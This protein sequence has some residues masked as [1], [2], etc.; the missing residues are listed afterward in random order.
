MHNQCL[1]AFFAAYVAGG[2][3][4]TVAVAGP[5]AE[6]LPVAAMNASDTAAAPVSNSAYLPGRDAL[7]AAAWSGQLTIGQARMETSPQLAQPLQDGRDARLFPGVSL[8]FFTDGDLLVPVQRG[9]MVRETQSM[10]TP[11]YWRVI[12]QFGRVWREPGDGN[13][14][15]AAVPLNL[16]NDTENHAHQGVATFLYRD[17]EISGLRMQFVQQTG[18]YL[19][20]Q[21][22][23]MWGTARATLAAGNIG[24]L[25]T[26]RDAAREEL[27]SRLPS[28]PWSELVKQFPP[29]T[30]DG[31]GGPLLPKWQVLNAL[32][33][34]GTL[35]HQES[36][37]PYGPFPYPLEMRFGVRSVMKSVAAPLALLRLAEVYGP[38]VLALKIG[39]YVKGLDPKF[40]R[41]RFIDAVNMATGFGGMG[42]LKTHPNDTSDGYL[43]GDYDAWYTAPSVADKI[44]QINKNLRPYPWEPGMVMRYRDQ[45]FFLLGLAIEGFLKSVRGVD[46]DLWDM[47]TTEVFKPIGVHH[48]PA[49]RTREP[50]NRDGVIWVN[51][52]YYPSIDDLAKIAALYQNLGSHNGKQLLHRQLTQNLL[53][54]RNAIV[55][56][57]DASLGFAASDVNQEQEKHYLMGF[58]YL[59]YVGSRSKKLHSIPA[60][61]GAGDNR[62]TIFPNGVIAVTMA[63][64][65]GLPPGENANNGDAQATLR[66]VDRMAPF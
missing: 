44:A 9:T 28:K 21:H 7:P 23:V 57:G 19:L 3:F 50:G 31:F 16:V 52:G 8:E 35:Y 24:A 39:D 45:D 17:G 34:K 20:N 53:A 49:V 11:S 55:Q 29:G 65:M 14:S 46:A 63:K 62:V 59:R 13:W 27:R 5:A 33:Y 15:R 10:A 43:D 37:T 61:H 38:Y 60:M 64:A 66:A 4:A 32:L 42:T 51:A 22:F 30:L 58:R 47:L 25:D 18:P 2:C 56:S 12:P 41:V 36:A 26:R 6:F 54:A 1:I 40:N 48:A